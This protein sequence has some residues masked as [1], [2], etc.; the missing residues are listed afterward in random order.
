MFDI[1]N[2]FTSGTNV[3]SISLVGEGKP[4]EEVTKMTTFVLDKKKIGAD[5]IGKTYSRIKNYL[6]KNFRVYGENSIMPNVGE[7]LMDYF[8]KHGS[9]GSLDIEKIVN[10]IMLRNTQSSYIDNWREHE[11]RSFDNMQKHSSSTGRMGHNRMVDSA[12][13]AFEQGMQ[14]HGVNRRKGEF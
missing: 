2:T 8:M 9:I 6:N 4:K 1:E 12:I 10:S 11:L 13:E 14:K 7:A 5:S 3:T